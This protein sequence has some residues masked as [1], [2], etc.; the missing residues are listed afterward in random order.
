MSVFAGYDNQGYPPVEH[1]AY[2]HRSGRTARAGATGDVVTVM[3]HEQRNDVRTLMRKAGIDPSAADIAP[4]DPR[5]ELLTGPPAA[6]VEPAA[7]APAPSRSRG[8]KP[9]GGS[10]RR[11]GRSRQASGRDRRR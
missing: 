1:K 5:I 8:A 2:L 10:G 3:T 4:G 7:P 9:G 11:G 6:H